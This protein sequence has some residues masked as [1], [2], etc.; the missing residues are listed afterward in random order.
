MPIPG[1][2]MR[3]L[4]TVS[5]S[6]TQNVMTASHRAERLASCQLF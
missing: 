2:R 5:V 3:Y 1:G 6:A 4:L